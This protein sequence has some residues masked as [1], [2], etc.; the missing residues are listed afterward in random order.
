MLNLIWVRSFLALV[1]R[2]SFQ[3]AAEALEIAQPTVSLH[4][5]K[6]EEQLGAV[7][8]H[9]SRTGCDPTREALN[10]LPYAESI[11][12]VNDRAMAS[13]SGDNLRIGASSNIGIYLLPPYV[14]SYLD[15]RGQPDVDIVIDRNPA[16]AQKLEAGEIDVAVMEWWDGR[17]GCHGEFWKR[18]PVVVIVP[19]GHE[20]AAHRVVERDQLSEY[21]LL[22]GEPGTGTGRLLAAYFGDASR[23][24]RVSR[25]LGSTEA[26]K[27]AVKAGLGISLVLASS[28]ADSVRAGSLI[29]IP[30]AGTGLSKELFIAW[31]NG[32]A[33]AHVSAFVR[34]LATANG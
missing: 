30:F 13:V 8:F 34:H 17:D 31:K 10:F 18:E 2:R 24:P 22:G 3:S 32:A 1:E 7:L 25:Q 5:Q 6:L 14:R 23:M 16:I 28:V 29:A 26:V 27:Q 20:L 15:E 9:R 11:I 4:I 33:A 19:P 12:R 21:E